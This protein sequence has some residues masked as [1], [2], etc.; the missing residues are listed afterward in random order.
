MCACL[1]H[2]QEPWKWHMGAMVN[3]NTSQMSVSGG[4]GATQTTGTQWSAGFGFYLKT[5][6]VNMLRLEAQLAFEATGAGKALYFERMIDE[7]IRIYDRYRT[8]PVSL[9]V[10]RSIGWKESWSVGLGGKSSFVVS[11]AVRHD[12]EHPGLSG[13]VISPDVRKCFGSGV[14]QISHHFLYAD[15]SLTGWYAFTPLIEYNSVKA[16]PYGISF[17][18]KKMLVPGKQN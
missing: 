14:I 4:Y 1:T 5:K 13:I 11:H 7:W 10:T 6:T 8:I 9:I 3:L 12:S 15:V 18:V 2:A 17:A 16:V